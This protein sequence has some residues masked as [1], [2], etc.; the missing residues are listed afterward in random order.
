M[1]NIMDSACRMQQKRITLKFGVT[2]PQERI[3]GEFSML[4]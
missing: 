3:Q 2:N 1:V 4:I